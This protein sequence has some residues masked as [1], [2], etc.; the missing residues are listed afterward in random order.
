MHECDV[1]LLA[2]RFA[3]MIVQ[4]PFTYS[5]MDLFVGYMVGENFL[6]VI[7]CDDV[8]VSNLRMRQNIC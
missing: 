3:V 1:T 6:Y 8:L 2:V 5:E 4:P 7:V